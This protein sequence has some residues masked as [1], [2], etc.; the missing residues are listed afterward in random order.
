LNRENTEVIIDFI[1]IDLQANVTMN[2][3]DM[4]STTIIINFKITF[5]T[6]A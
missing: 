6:Y 1:I 3:V 4:K 2:M 5:L